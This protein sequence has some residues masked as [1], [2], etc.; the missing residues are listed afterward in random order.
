MSVYRGIDFSSFYDLSI[1][2]W[3]CSDS[4]VFFFLHLIYIVNNINVITCCSIVTIVELDRFNIQLKT[5]SKQD[6]SLKF[7]CLHTLLSNQ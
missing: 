1:R 6:S 3:N 2:L 5:F 7:T 4:V